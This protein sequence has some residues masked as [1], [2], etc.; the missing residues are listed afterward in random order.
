MWR[1]PHEKLSSFK[2]ISKM[3]FTARYFSRK[4]KNL[5]RIFCSE[6]SEET[7]VYFNSAHTP[8]N[9]QFL[10]IVIFWKP[11]LMLELI[12]KAIEFWQTTHFTIFQKALFLTFARSIILVLKAELILN[13]GRKPWTKYLET[14]SNFGMV[15]LHHKQSETKLLSPEE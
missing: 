8:W 3:L 6:L 13:Q 1:F 11:F 15:F 12:V 14:L 7:L 10:Y 2:K 5:S 9:L 4:L